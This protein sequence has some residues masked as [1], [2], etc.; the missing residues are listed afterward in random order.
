MRSLKGVKIV[1][2]FKVIECLNIIF[3]RLNK[4]TDIQ[5]LGIINQRGHIRKKIISF[6]LLLI[7]QILNIFTF[8]SYM[9]GL[10]IALNT[11]NDFILHLIL[12]MNYFEFKKIGKFKKNAAITEFILN[13]NYYLG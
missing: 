7:F 2:F 10:S 3:N 11:S 12:K 9:I 5:L 13:G 8:W 4:D 6:I 1:A